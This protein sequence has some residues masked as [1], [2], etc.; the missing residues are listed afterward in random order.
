ML[1]PSTSE[2]DNNEASEHDLEEQ[3]RAQSDGTDGDASDAP[4]EEE[5]SD[6]DAE[7][8]AADELGEEETKPKKKGVGKGVIF[9]GVGVGIILVMCGVAYVM[10]G[11]MQQQAPVAKKIAVDP[12]LLE[13]KPSLPAEPKLEAPVVASP[14]PLGTP[15][16]NEIV[17]NLNGV[18]AVS[19]I[20]SPPS[21][22]FAAPAVPGASATPAASAVVPPVI[23]VVPPVAPVVSTPTPGVA[24]TPAPGADPFGSL[25]PEK[26][27]KV[28]KSVPEKVEMP[29]ATIPAKPAKVVTPRPVEIEEAEISKP[30]PVAAKPR[31]R[32]PSVVRE[33]TSVSQPH[34]SQERVQPQSSESFHGYEK[35]F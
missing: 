24:I 16:G 30:R 20:S 14:N 13:S 4:G 11:Q 17:P 21:D 29:V 28:E 12:S 26:V 18:P 35:L 3:M 34:P 6:V 15:A 22:P 7:L 19:A 5:L 23:P 27:P 25:T 33:D 31:V 10:Q 2:Y 8:E 1:P 32:K 9:A